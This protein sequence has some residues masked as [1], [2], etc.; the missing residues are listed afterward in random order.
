MVANCYKIQKSTDDETFQEPGHFAKRKRGRPKGSRK[1][2]KG[3]QREGEANTCS[4]CQDRLSDPVT[5]PCGHNYCMDC[6]KTQWD[7]QD[8]GMIYSCPQCGQTFTPKPDLVKNI[9]KTVLEKKLK[10]TRLQGPPDDHCYAG[11]KD[12]AHGVGKRRRPK[13]AKCCSFC[14]PSHCGKP[15]RS[16][17]ESPP[18]KKHKLVDPPKMMTMF[19]RADQQR[20]RYLYCEDQ[21]GGHDTVSAAAERTQRQRELKWSWQEIHQDRQKDVKVLEQQVGTVKVEGGGRFRSH[22]QEMAKDVERKQLTRPQDSNHFPFNYFSQLTHSSSIN[23]RP[24]RFTDDLKDMSEISD[25]LQD[26]LTW[27]NISKIPVEVSLPQPEPKTRAEFLRYTKEITVDPNTVHRRLLLSEGNEKVTITGEEQSYPSHPDRFI[28]EW[29]VLSKESLTG[30]CYWEVEWRGG[31]GVG[32]AV[33][34]KNISRAGRSGECGFGYNDQSWVLDCYPKC[35]NFL[36]NRV[37]TEGS[38]GVS[39]RVGVYLDHSAGT[40]S[41]YS[42]SVSMTLLHRVRTMFT[43]PLYAGVGLFYFGS[44]AEVCKLK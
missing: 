11:S 20:I 19:C 39:S 35:C 3:V 34:Y 25:Q 15:L 30:R 43:Q 23:T 26:F 33:T 6:I 1:V 38:G 14:L 41:F 5:I 7:L 27:T 37:S 40:L 21:H 31:G 4:I 28:D 12:E 29:Q 13:A 8:E 2:Q 22:Q 44:T 16:S 18:F 9:V 24:L 17:H 42:V 36:H 32:V 10:K